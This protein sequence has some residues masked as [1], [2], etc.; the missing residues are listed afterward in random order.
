MDKVTPVTQSTLHISEAVVST[1]VDGAL[2]ELDGVYGLANLPV[3]MKILA[4]PATARP[5]RI[6]ITA[7]TAQ[8]DVGVILHWNCRLK[9]V[10]EQIQAATKD[11]VQNMTGITVSKVN[12]FVLG[13]HVPNASSE[14]KK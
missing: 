13:V 1:I 12:V 10:C 5:V 8:I 4:T 3:K 6:Y 11:A 2:K 9:D 14:A 7:D